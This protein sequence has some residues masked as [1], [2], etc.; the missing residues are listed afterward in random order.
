MHSTDRYPD[1]ANLTR[2]AEGFRTRGYALDTIVQDWYFWPANNENLLANH[3][4]DPAR[5]SSPSAMTQTVLALNIS[6]MVT[7]W[8]A[9]SA[10]NALHD[11]L[12]QAKALLGAT[13]DP[14]S[15]A[16]REL[17]YGYANASKYA[18]GVQYSWLDSTDCMP[19]EANALGPGADFALTF[20][21]ASTRSL[22]DGIRRDYPLSRRPFMLTRS[23]FAGQQRHGAV[24]W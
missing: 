8:P 22:F 15:G 1:Q 20:S 10:G 6:L 21:L 11:A 19:K 13:Y 4:F 2:G 7:Y 14:Y 9:I 12:T 5:Y 17:Y 3:G 24:L 18:M 23:S 16:G